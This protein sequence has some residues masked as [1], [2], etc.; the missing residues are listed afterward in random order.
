MRNYDELTLGELGGEIADLRGR[1]AAQ[2]ST[3]REQLDAHLLARLAPLDPRA[4]LPGMALG[5]DVSLAGTQ[6]AYPAAIL[7]GD[8]SD[9][10]VTVSVDT[11]LVRDMYYDN[12]VVNAGV[13]LSTGGFRLFVKGTLVNNGYVSHNGQPA[14]GA[15]GGAGAAAGAVGGGAAGGNGGATAGAGSAGSSK[16]SSFGGAGGA[17]GTA[18]GA[19]G[20]GGAATAPVA[21]LGTIRDLVSGVRGRLLD[22]TPVQGGA[23]GGGGGGSATNPGGGGGGAGGVVL[24]VGRAIDNTSGIIEAQGGDGA[25]VGAG[26]GGGGGG[27][28]GGVVI[29]VYGVL[30]GG[31]NVNAAEGLGGESPVAFGLPG[32][33]GTV[34]GVG[35]NAFG[36]DL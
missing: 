19:G 9:G 7:Y 23:G 31:S 4:G 32:A 33:A 30:L 13:R 11:T 14:A 26:F 8:G 12:L 29:L 36:L 5:G 16:S 25:T 27:G 6:G 18:T 22:A 34:I 21:A 24:I 17:G 28:G 10:D 15:S 20:A 35:G 2:E 3:A 1:L